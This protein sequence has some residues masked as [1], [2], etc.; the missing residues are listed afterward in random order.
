MRAFDK[1]DASHWP[2]ARKTGHPAAAGLFAASERRDLWRG[3]GHE[4]RDDRRDQRQHEHQAEAL[5]I[6]AE[7]IA[8][9]AADPERLALRVC[10]AGHG[11]APPLRRSAAT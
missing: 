1:V 8:G 7:S 10:I 3:A 5:E 9:N 2:S 11:L 6:D 4:E